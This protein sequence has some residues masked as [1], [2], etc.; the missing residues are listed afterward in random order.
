MIKNVLT[1]LL[2]LLTTSII[3]QNSIIRGTVLQKNKT[4]ISSVNIKLKGTNK[5]ATTG[6][7]GSFEIKNLNATNYSITISMLGYETK[8][9]EFSCKPNS[10]NNLGDIILNESLNQLDE[11]TINGN[12]KSKN[13][14]SSSLRLKTPIT[15]LPQNIQVVDNE[16]LE[17]QMITN[18]LDGAFRNVSG[19]SNIEHWGHFARINM[20]GF[21]LPAFRNGFNIQ[22]SWG[23]LSEDMFMVDRIEFVKGP[24]GFMMSA[25]EPGGFYNVVTKKP[26]EQKIANISFMGGSFDTYRAAADVG[27]ALTEDKRLLARLNVMYQNTGSHRKFEDTERF[28]IAPSI[29]YKISDKTTFLTEFTYQKLNTLI[30]AAYVF[31]SVDRGYGSL[32]KN[33]TMI[34]SNFPSTDIKEVSLLN[35]LTHNFND[36]WSIEAQYSVMRYDQEGA[37]AWIASLQNNGDAI[38]TTGIWD[39]ISESEYFQLYTNGK[40]NTGNISHK[41]LGGYDYT[42]KEYFADFSQ[43]V[44]VDLPTNPFNIYNPTYGNRVIPVF[45]RSTPLKERQG[46]YTYGTKINS[47][48]LQDE[49][50]F[51]DNKIRLTLAGRYTELTPK[52]ANKISKI[53]PRIGLSADINSKLTVYG[54]YDQSFL[55]P[56]GIPRNGVTFD[57]I[58]GNIIEAGIKTKLMDNKITASLSAY[59]ITKNNLSVPDPNNI[60]GEQFSVQL[61]EVESKGFEFDMTAQITEE[62]DVLLNYANT[63]AKTTKSTIPSMVGNRIAGH[64]K[65]ITNGWLNYK[66]N[67]NS[68]LKGFG[69]SLGYQYLV[70]RSS[71]TWNANNQTDLPNYFR[72]D[73]AIHWKNDKLRIG[74]NINNILNEHLYSGANYGSYLYWQS[75]P[76]INGRLSINYNLF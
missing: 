45:N 7:N 2:L 29:S 49:L 21:R 27:G 41:I 6:N 24:S 23:P 57:P 18:M 58:S 15:Q 56:T 35:R 62:F 20:R 11:V 64:A 39:A 42:D 60:T 53:T 47:L 40:F 52:G 1:S 50:G 38:R 68:T 31:G 17:T 72:L 51:I 46:V 75:E 12:K 33:F 36:N 14:V 67:K 44:L 9:I 8:T 54:L 32:D 55:A 13:K 61:G 69:I 19:V 30:G 66:F 70:D 37:S 3:A 65:H 25:G 4:P 43:S 34:D 63:N 5:G 28:G 22:D 26:T 16:L 10:V 48:Y 59:M 73:G 76:G 71:W 74:L